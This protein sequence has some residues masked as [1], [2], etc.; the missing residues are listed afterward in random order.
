VAGSV[1]HPVWSPDST[2]IA[3]VSAVGAPKP[4]TEQ[5]AVEKAAPRIVRGLGAR[6]D[7]VGWFDGRRHLF[8]V[9]VATGVLRQVT[10][11]DWDD[12]TPAWSDDGELLVFSSDRSRRRDDHVMRSDAWLV[13]AAGGQ[14]RRVSSGKGLASFPSFSPGGRWI[15]F[16]GGEAGEG[17]WNRDAKLL[18]VAADGMGVPTVVAQALDRPIATPARGAQSPFVWLSSDE[19]LFLA[20]DRGAV[21]AYRAQ[22]TDSQARLVVGG[23]RQLDGLS[24]STGVDRVA[25]TSSWPDRPSEVGVAALD[26]ANERQVSHANDTFSAEI[27]LAPI[28][29]AVAVSADGLEVE[30]FTL[31][32]PGDDGA[33]LPLHLEIHGGPHGMHPSGQQLAY[34]QTIAAAGYLVLMPNPRGS[35]S[36]GQAFTEGCTGAWGDGDFADVMSCVDDVVELGSADPDRLHVSGYSYGG[37]MTTWAVGHTDRF[38]AAVVG[39]PVIDQVSMLGTTD[40]TNFAL[41]NMGGTPWERPE[42]YAKRSP[43]TYLPN[44]KTPVLIQHWESDLRCPMGQSEQL[45]CGLRLLGKEVELVRYPGGSH[46]SRSPSQALDRVRRLLDWYRRFA[47]ES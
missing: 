41:F 8:V 4:S 26:G 20:S 5:T 9:D 33:A 6:R 46:I 25:F 43:L 15:A 38:R 23:A 7:N 2:R 17:G 47:S 35:T 32:P 12:D 24:A 13:P 30:Y 22:V 34:L 1:S 27:E 11:G 37:F 42:E 21:C 10:R 45:Y 14:P 19:L 44:I 29:R 36:Y 39:A 18:V 31:R 3:F 40:I 16:A 28:R